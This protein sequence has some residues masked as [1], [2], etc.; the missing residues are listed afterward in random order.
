M[1]KTKAK[2]WSKAKAEAVTISGSTTTY[3]HKTRGNERWTA[4]HSGVGLWG[5]GATEPA[6]LADLD[7]KIV[8]AGKAA[9]AARVVA[10]AP[11]KAPMTK[12]PAKPVQRSATARLTALLGE[13]TAALPPGMTFLDWYESPDESEFRGSPARRHAASGA[14]D[15]LQGM[16]EAYDLTVRE[17]FDAE[18]VNYYAPGEQGNR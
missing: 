7:A 11:A 8:A 14:W 12:A 18:E 15:T 3:D 13:I 5:Y 17:L 10:K 16:G 9:P 4:Y 6:A 1:A 2:S